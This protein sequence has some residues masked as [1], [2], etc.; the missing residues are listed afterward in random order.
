[1]KKEDNK[2]KIF[3]LIILFFLFRKN[4][5]EPAKATV[6]T[7]D[8]NLVGTDTGIDW[9]GNEVENT[10]NPN[11]VGIAPIKPLPANPIVEDYTELINAPD[12]SQNPTKIPELIYVNN[13]AFER[14][15]DKDLQETIKQTQKPL[16]LYQQKP[17]AELANIRTSANVSRRSSG[18]SSRTIVENGKPPETFQTPK[19]Y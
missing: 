3:V 18:G 17:T 16:E 8:L 12:I 6:E 19:L 15:T 11:V 7:G 13:E 14:Y 1:M 2:I 5:N 4:K 9:D 10:G